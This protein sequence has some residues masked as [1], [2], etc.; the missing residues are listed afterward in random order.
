MPKPQ[1]VLPPGDFQAYLF[2]CD[3]TVADSMPLHFIAWTEALSEWGCLFSEERFYEWGGVPI[4]EIIERLGREQHI[5]MPIA[6]VARRKE[7]L[8]FEHLPRLKAIPEV[9]EHI[10]SHW[11]RIPFAV[12]SG[13]TRDSVEASLRMIGLIEK[14][15]TLV[16]AGDYTKS[17]PDPEP[18]LMAAQKLGVPPEAC[19]VF[20]DTQMGIDAAR[21]AGI[22]WVRVPDPRTRSNSEATK[23]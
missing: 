21:A 10:E 15:K 8:Y 11:G 12:V 14:F 7:Q 23:L 22:A 18:F 16:C 9:L 5:T 19:L 17:K 4:V 2:D 6:D 20:E 1:L 3:G 13:S